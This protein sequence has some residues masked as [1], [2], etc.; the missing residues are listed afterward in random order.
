[1]FPVANSVSEWSGFSDYFPLPIEYYAISLR[2][3][4]AMD[5]E[6]IGELT[7]TYE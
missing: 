6:N 4:T 2:L 5:T 1:V 3:S 7:T